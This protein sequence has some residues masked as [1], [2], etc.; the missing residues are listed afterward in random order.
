MDILI[1]EYYVLSF[2]LFGFVEF[3]ILIYLIAKTPAL[4]FLKASLTHRMMLIHPRENHYI[5]FIPAKATSSL[6]YVKGR[7]Y[8]LTDPKHVFIEG[9]SKVP[10]AIVY[11]N[12]ALNLDLKMAKLAE[13]LKD[14]GIRYYDEILK[15]RDELVKRGQT[16]IINLLGESIDVSEAIN[17]FNTSERSDFIE[18]EIQRRTASQVMQ[19]LRQPGD[20]LKWAIIGMILMIGAAIAYA[21]IAQFI[22]GP[23]P[24][25]AIQQV[26]RI[27]APVPTNASMAVS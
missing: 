15:L 16:L 22:G 2:I 14:M 18:A 20:L 8:Y 13:R 24:A 6:A 5:E 10:C 17:Y 9:T 27:I 11:G 7:G 21:I 23:S 26:G 3:I 12:F 25:Q 19:R 4:K 1:S